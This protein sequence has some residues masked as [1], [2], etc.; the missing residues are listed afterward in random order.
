MYKLVDYLAYRFIMFCKKS[1]LLIVV[2]MIS[3]YFL[4]IYIFGEIERSMGETLPSYFDFGLIFIYM[5]F[6]FRVNYVL[7]RLK[8]SEDL[9]E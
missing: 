6:H 7:K 2:I 1:I 4:V 3:T 9:E 5:V 8:E